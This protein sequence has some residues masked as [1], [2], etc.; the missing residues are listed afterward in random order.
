M[1]AVASD[2][3][4]YIVRPTAALEYAV[5]MTA[6]PAGD[7]DDRFAAKL[8]SVA[9][10][11]DSGSRLYWSLVDS[12]DAEHASCHHHDFL[13]SGLMITQ[14]SCD[15]ADVDPLLTRIL[16][17]YREAATQGI[18]QQEFSQARNKLAGR[19]VLEGERPRRRLF[20]V[21]L[22]WAHGGVYRSV[23]DNLRIVENLSV[24]DLERVMAR[25]PLDGPGVTV[26]AGPAGAEPSSPAG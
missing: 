10:G 3:L 24:A 5:R 17:M 14:L 1:K 16:D 20:H 26:L 12:G 11:D 13:D 21:G 7:D 4:D 22:E 19:V 18:S 15:A 23:A 9:L 25:W 8:L 6:G 2:H